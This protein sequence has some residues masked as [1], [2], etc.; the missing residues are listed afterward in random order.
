[1]STPASPAGE[2]SKVKAR[3]RVTNWRDYDRALVQRGSLDIWFDEGFVREHWRPAAS[4]R[5]GAPFLYSDLAIQVLLTMKAVFALPYR[6]L[7]GFA[8]SLMR[9]T[10]LGLLVPDHPQMSRRAR[11]LRVAI[12][13]RPRLGPIPVVVDSTGLKVFGEGEW[14]VRQ[15]GAGKRRTWLKV[16]LAVDADAKDVIGVE[17]TTTAWGD[18][19]VF[20]GLLDQVEGRIGQVDGDGAYDTREVYEAGMARGADVVVPPRENAVPWE[21]GHPRTR[22]LAAITEQGVEGWKASSGYHRRSLAENAMYRLKQ[23]FGGSV[24]SRVFEAQVTEVH[25]RIAALNLMTYLG[26]PVSVR[27]GVTAP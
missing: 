9:L 14:K 8:G 25:V 4:G 18:G 24:A 11:T 19:E 12:P 23:L 6:A 16:H 17:V 1:M 7:E 5:R 26:M 13:R 20:G 10:G 21:A 15:H 27:V 22:A 2:D 3:Y